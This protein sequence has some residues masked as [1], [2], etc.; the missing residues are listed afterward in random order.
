MI[1]LE[2][3]PLPI[4]HGSDRSATRKSCGPE[5]PAPRWASRLG[6]S[7][8]L[9]KQHVYMVQQGPHLPTFL[10]GFS[11]VPPMLQRVFVVAWSTRSRRTAMHPTTSFSIT[12][13][14]MQALLE[15]VLA[16]QRRLDSIGRVLRG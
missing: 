13:G 2:L 16:P 14:D 9:S 10:N 6:R 12:A 11:R 8:Y 4:Q 7:F 3:M 1:G 15:R 5:E